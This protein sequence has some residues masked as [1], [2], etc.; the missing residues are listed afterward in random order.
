[1]TPALSKQQKSQPNYRLAK[2]LDANSKV[3]IGNTLNCTEAA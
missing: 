1:M 3:N 2:L